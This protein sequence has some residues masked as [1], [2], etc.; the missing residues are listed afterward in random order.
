M[1]TGEII[2]KFEK[3]IK[4]IGEQAKAEMATYII[5]NISKIKENHDIE[6]IGI[7][8]PGTPKRRYINKPCKPRR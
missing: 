5:E 8:S 1:K 3:D 2:E 6:E 7:G 4:T